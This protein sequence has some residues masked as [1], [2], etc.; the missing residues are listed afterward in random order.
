MAATGESFVQATARHEAAWATR[1]SAPIAVMLA[2]CGRGEEHERVVAML[3]TAKIAYTTVFVETYKQ[4]RLEVGLTELIGEHQIASHLAQVRRL[5]RTISEGYPSSLE[6]A[7]VISAS[8][9]LDKL[10]QAWPENQPAQTVAGDTSPRGQLV[11]LVERWLLGNFGRET[12]DASYSLDL[13]FELV[14]EWLAKM[15]LEH[16]LPLTMGDRVRFGGDPGAGW[17]VR[18]TTDRFA[19]CVR[20]SANKSASL[21]RSY[22]HTLVDWEAN[23]RG[24][25]SVFK[26]YETATPEVIQQLLSDAAVEASR[27]GNQ[28]ELVIASSGRPR[29]SADE[30]GPTTLYGLCEGYAAGELSREQLMKAL[31]SWDYVP[32]RH[33]KPLT[34]LSEENQ[35]VVHPVG[36][37]ADLE[38]AQE[39]DLIDEELFGEVMDKLGA[40]WPSAAATGDAYCLSVGLTADEVA[41]GMILDTPSPIQP[42]L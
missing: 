35:V 41:R 3:D 38:R 42:T 40:V 14:E 15:R 27:Y 28:R 19:F 13:G 26:G 11:T 18:A 34:Y 17:E 39:N 10:L 2:T 29:K 36:S 33:Y 24:E 7:A 25:V 21:P 22:S 12:S 9:S 5:S 37:V 4:P 32:L 30:D 16:R 6:V 20:P 23:R 31:L 1:Q 8:K